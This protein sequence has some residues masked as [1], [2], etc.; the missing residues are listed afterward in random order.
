MPI[1]PKNCVCVCVAFAGVCATVVAVNAGKETAGVCGTAVAAAAAAAGGCKVKAGAGVW[2]DGMDSGNAEAG[3]AGIAA[4][5]DVGLLFSLPNGAGV[6][7]SAL[8]ADEVDEEEKL[9]LLTGRIVQLLV[10]S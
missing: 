9:E 6:L 1:K 7:S 8:D 2:N 10:F 4:R 3:V 5:E